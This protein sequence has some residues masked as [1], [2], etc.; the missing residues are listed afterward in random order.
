MLYE[1]SDKPKA[2]ALILELSYEQEN[3][4]NLSENGNFLGKMNLKRRHKNFWKVS[5]FN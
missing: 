1:D 3:L 5:F 2:T 4:K